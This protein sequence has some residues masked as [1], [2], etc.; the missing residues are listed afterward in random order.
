MPPATAD[1]GRK[2]KTRKSSAF[3]QTNKS[4]LSL[5]R[6]LF[7]RRRAV[8]SRKWGGRVPTSLASSTEVPCRAA[9]F[10]PPRVARAADKLA[11]HRWVSPRPARLWSCPCGGAQRL[12]APPAR[13][14]LRP[15]GP[16][17]HHSD[18]FPPGPS[19]PTAL[20]KCFPLGNVYLPHTC[21]I[22]AYGTS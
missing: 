8:S 14:S 12:P 20:L 17:A 22:Q 16:H 5:E 4:P 2:S 15:C 11:G 13:A 19:S 21:G 1:A 9:S 18:G 6:S 3:S 7:P 10:I